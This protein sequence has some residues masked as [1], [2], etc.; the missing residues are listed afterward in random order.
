MPEKRLSQRVTEK[1]DSIAG[2]AATLAT[3]TP[4]RAHIAGKTRDVAM[5]PPPVSIQISSIGALMDTVRKAFSL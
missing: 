2:G 4:C 5:T 3:D 1:A